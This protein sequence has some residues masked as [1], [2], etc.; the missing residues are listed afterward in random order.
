MRGRLTPKPAMAG[1]VG[2][3]EPGDE[4]GGERLRSGSGAAG[5]PSDIDGVREAGLRKAVKGGTDG[6]SLS[7]KPTPLLGDAFSTA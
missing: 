7:S 5:L 6:T 4:R 3:D 1:C 2:G